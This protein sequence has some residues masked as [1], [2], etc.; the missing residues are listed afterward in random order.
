MKAQERKNVVFG[1]F[2]QKRKSNP[3]TGEPRGQQ[4]EFQQRM[5]KLKFVMDSTSL[6]IN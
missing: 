6:F 3:T 4:V 5:L 1:L 2:L